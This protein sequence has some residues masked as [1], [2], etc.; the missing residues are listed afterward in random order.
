MWLL[1]F[2]VWKIPNHFPSFHL[3]IHRENELTL[4]QLKANY[5]QTPTTY[6]VSSAVPPIDTTLGQISKE[7]AK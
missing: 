7:P 1:L 4:Q 5:V 6:T 3:S 2:F